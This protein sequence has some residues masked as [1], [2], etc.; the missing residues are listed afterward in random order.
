MRDKE[1]KGVMKDK[2]AMKE[3]Q[4][5]QQKFNMHSDRWPIDT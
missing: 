1:T 4:K 2:V 3:S 5:D